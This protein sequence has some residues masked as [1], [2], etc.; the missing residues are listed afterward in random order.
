VDR[1]VSDRIAELRAWIAE[2]DGAV[3]ATVGRR[4]D[5]VRELREVKSA[6]GLDFLDPEQERRLED[7]LVSANTGSLSEAGVR[8]LVAAV[9]ALTK[10]ELERS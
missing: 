10:R 8:E 5:L 3:L 7:A 1:P 4:I 9:L 2:C 6:A